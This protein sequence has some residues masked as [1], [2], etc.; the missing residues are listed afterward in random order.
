MKKTSVRVSWDDLVVDMIEAEELKD[1]L[2][3][4]ERVTNRVKIGRAH[5]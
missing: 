2:A 5:V 1:A 4:H 3:V